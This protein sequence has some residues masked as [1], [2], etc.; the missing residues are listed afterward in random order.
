MIWSSKMKELTSGMIFDIQISLSSDICIFHSGK[1]FRFTKE[2]NICSNSSII[3]FSEDLLFSHSENL[4]KFPGCSVFL[5]TGLR[6]Y[7]V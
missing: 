4:G 7:Y 6:T 3:V 5:R 2:E 1:I